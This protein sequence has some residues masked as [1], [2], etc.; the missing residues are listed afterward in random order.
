VARLLA[1]VGRKGAGK[2]TLIERLVPEL[3]RR[4]H[5]VGTVKRPPHHF[6][7]DT[8]GKDSYRHFHSGADVSVVYHGEVAAA[9]FR[10]EAGTPV[11]QLADHLMPGCDVVLV[12]G[13]KTSDIPKIE[14]YRRGVGEGPLWPE[15]EGVVAVVS[16]EDVEPGVPVLPLTDVGAIASFVER[17]LGLRGG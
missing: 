8:P 17:A 14:V 4:G 1:I 12:E 7:A 11:S 15:L 5:R 16:D 2:T 9:F 3:K 10:I 13:H 6:Q